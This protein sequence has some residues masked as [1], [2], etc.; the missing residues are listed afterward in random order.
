MYSYG[1]N[2]RAECSSLAARRWWC[3]QAAATVHFFGS[4]AGPEGRAC[5][6][7]DN[8]SAFIARAHTDTHALLLYYY[9]TRRV[10]C[11]HTRTRHSRERREKARV[12]RARPRPLTIH[13]RSHSFASHQT[14]RKPGGQIRSRPRSRS[15]SLVSHTTAADGTEDDVRACFA[16]QSAHRTA[17]ASVGLLDKHDRDY[18]VRGDFWTIDRSVDRALDCAVFG[19]STSVLAKSLEQLDR[20]LLFV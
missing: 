6:S 17:T 18:G 19:D 7:M 9:T 2:N 3:R 11:I 10:H 14:R 16:L 20:L 13:K 5:L 12:C 1:T 15:P 4:G 8:E